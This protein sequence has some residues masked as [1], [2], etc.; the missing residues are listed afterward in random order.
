[1]W[2]FCRA[3]DRE[4]FELLNKRALGVVYNGQTSTYEELL[5]CVGQCSLN[6]M[7]IQDHLLLTFKVVHGFNLPGYLTDLIRLRSSVKDLRGLYRLEIPRI[8]TTAYGLHSFRYS[9][10]KRWND[11]DESVRNLSKISNI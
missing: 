8:N 5:E 2:H 11:L 6:D 10:A 4:K 7:R 9:A 3:S 1:M